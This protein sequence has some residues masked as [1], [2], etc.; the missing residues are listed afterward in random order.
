M[1]HTEKLWR[2]Q[3]LKQTTKM[4]RSRK[5]RWPILTF[6]VLLE[7]HCWDAW[8]LGRTLGVGAENTS[9]KKVECLDLENSLQ[10]TPETGIPRWAGTHDH[11]AKI[12]N[13][14]EV[15]PLDFANIV[16]KSLGGSG[17]VDW[18]NKYTVIQSAGFRMK[19]G[20]QWTGWSSSS[21]QPHSTP[22]SASPTLLRVEKAF[23][24]ITACSL[25]V[26]GGG[27]WLQ[28]KLNSWQKF[29]MSLVF[30]GFKQT[31]RIL[32]EASYFFKK[33]FYTSFQSRSPSKR[34]K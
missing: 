34:G 10:A 7:R 4:L 11:F 3:T 19:S 23:D 27:Q 15:N 33:C 31:F 14:K 6:C 26:K 28:G 13:Q 17:I 8:V 1:E 30:D 20:R 5:Q 25:A 29:K 21:E 32:H 22:Q 16:A 2:Y 24:P 18:R 12:I 9:Q